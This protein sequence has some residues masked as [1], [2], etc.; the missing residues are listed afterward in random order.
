MYELFQ[1]LDVAIVKELFLEV[2][3]RG[4]GCGTLRG[5]HGY[6]ARRGRLH[7]AVPRW[8][9]LCPIRIRIG[10]RTETASEERPYSQV[11]VPES[12]WIRVEAEEIRRGLIIEGIPGI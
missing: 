7:S 4:L 11:P 10:P 9:K 5:C 6:V 2:R 3:P 8:C 1:A 12:I